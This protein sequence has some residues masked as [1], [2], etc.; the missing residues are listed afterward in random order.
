MPRRSDS[1]E[2]MLASATRLLRRQGYAATG[3]REVVAEGDAPWGSQAH[4]FPGG[5]EQLAAEALAR[6]GERMRDEI[7]S[8]LSRS[9]PAEMIRHW[10][11]SASAQ[12]EASGWS[13]G[14]PIATTALE[15]A[16]TSDELAGVCQAAFSS[17]QAAL[18]DAMTTRGVANRDARALA[19]LVVAATEGAL[20]L[21]RTERDAAPLRAVSREL[22]S[23]LRER[24]AVR[25]L[26]QRPVVVA[27]MGGGPSTVDLVVAAAEAGA[28][29]FLAAAYR[30]AQDV[31]AQL[32]QVRAR[33]S[34]PFGVNVFVPGRAAA[35]PRAVTRYA[36]TLEQEAAR[37]GV[38]LGTPAWDDDGWAAKI[39]VLV[40][41]APAVCSFT[42][43]CP[44]RAIVDGLRRRGTAVMVTAT[45]AAEAAAASD[46]GADVLCLQGIEAGAHR[47]T[48]VDDGEDEQLPLLDLVAA[49]R[50]H[51]DVPLVAA[52][53]IA[54]PLDV[55]AAL[56]AGASAVQV[57]T[58]FLRCDESG[59]SDLHKN[60]LVDPTFETTG[61]TR[62]FTGRRARGLVNR[63]MRD[64]DN[65]PIAYPE[66]H[67]LTRPLRA[68]AV[69]RGDA[70]G[71]NLWAGTGHRHS[72][73]GSAADIVA[74]LADGTEP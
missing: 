53:G 47:G 2:R 35:D 36:W 69:E 67:H 62:A 26:W 10:S 56:A 55:A 42:F 72:R 60:A 5:K 30:T 48:F 49:V 17:W 70:G 73:T 20:L 11:S 7:A 31:E 29:G 57:G 39:E 6:E 18:T 23:L 41:A 14:C 24:G 22:A 68:A 33:T 27:P 3:W 16:H 43:G 38:A 45:S 63:F 8:A 64:H 4:H 15:T 71:T 59:A 74:W 12:L 13:D 34:R 40:D 25:D 19:A 28:L 9:H 32:R 37:L 58:A 65:A 61:L 51:S 44:D 52:G 66:V 1:R 54:T 46:A 50:A 21:A